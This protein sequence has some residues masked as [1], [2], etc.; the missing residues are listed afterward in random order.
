MGT[1]LTLFGILRVVEGVSRVSHFSD[2]LLAVAAV[3]FLASGLSSCFALKEKG[4]MWKRRFDHISH[5]LFTSSIVV[6]GIICLIVVLHAINK[7]GLH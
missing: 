7:T 2:E 1:C 3:G 5:M 6:L 4:S